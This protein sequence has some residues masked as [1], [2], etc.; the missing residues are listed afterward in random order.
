MLAEAI[1]ASAKNGAP[2]LSTVHQMMLPVQAQP[3]NLKM[4]GGGA[5]AGMEVSDDTTEA[6]FDGVTEEAAHEPESYTTNAMA[7]V[8]EFGP[9]VPQP[10]AAK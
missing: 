1:G 7:L 10:T 8:K 2:I 4:E 6:D 5:E 9:Y 3:Q